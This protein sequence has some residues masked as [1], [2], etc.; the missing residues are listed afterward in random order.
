MVVNLPEIFFCMLTHGHVL[1]REVYQL[2]TRSRV[3]P[4]SIGQPIR[5]TGCYTI[6]AGFYR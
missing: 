4:G 1:Q 2:E 3:H 6:H 5:T